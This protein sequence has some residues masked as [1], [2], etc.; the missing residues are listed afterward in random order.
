MSYG[1]YVKIDDD[2]NC[3]IIK[4]GEDLGVE[5]IEET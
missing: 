2:F 3:D 1:Y 4:K 5:T